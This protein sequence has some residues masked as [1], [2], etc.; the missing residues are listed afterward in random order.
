M[1]CA[2]RVSNEK[3]IIFSKG[4][5]MFSLF[6][7]RTF[8]H[9]YVYLEYLILLI[10]LL[11]SFSYCIYFCIIST[12]ISFNIDIVP[13]HGES[14]LVESFMFGQGQFK[15]IVSMFIWFCYLEWVIYGG[16]LIWCDLLTSKIYQVEGI[17]LVSVRIFANK[18]NTWSV[19]HSAIQFSFKIKTWKLMSMFYFRY[20]LS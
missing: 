8:F 6:V 9:L 15:T 17:V 7:S 14:D 16:K 13:M 3:K 10:L 2:E 11:I 4:S 18:V 19:C 20:I 1:L 12:T 5:L